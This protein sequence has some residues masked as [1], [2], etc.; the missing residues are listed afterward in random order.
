MA[1]TPSLELTAQHLS[2]PGAVQQVSPVHLRQW[3]IVRRHSK[4]WFR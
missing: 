2:L 4:F 1:G 3:L